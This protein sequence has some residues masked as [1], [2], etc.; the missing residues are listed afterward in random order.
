MSPSEIVAGQDRDDD[1]S[2][3]SRSLHR[4]PPGGSGSAGHAVVVPLNR[5]EHAVIHERGR[6][7]A[8]PVRQASPSGSLPVGGPLWPGSTSPWIPVPDRWLL[9]VVTHDRGGRQNG[10]LRPGRVRVPEIDILETQGQSE[11]GFVAVRRYIAA[12]AFVARAGQDRVG[13]HIE[14][15]RRFQA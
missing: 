15:I 10:V 5:T 2:C 8:R 6:D 1:G 9:H 14:E 7:S 11:S 12:V 4:G 13:D 3:R